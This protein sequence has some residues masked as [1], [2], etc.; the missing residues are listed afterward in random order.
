LARHC[1]VAARARRDAYAASRC[2]WTAAMPP[3]AEMGTSVSPDENMSLWRCR[4]CMAAVLHKGAR[5]DGSRAGAPPQA[6]EH[7]SKLFEPDTQCIVDWLTHGSWT[8]CV[9][10]CGC[11]AAIC[12]ISYAHIMTAELISSV[13]AHPCFCDHSHSCHTDQMCQTRVSSTSSSQCRR[14]AD[15]RMG[16]LFPPPRLSYSAD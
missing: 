16:E 8:L 14:K 9:T 15:Q 10:W 2:G 7:S 4:H 3:M 13:V 12:S 6:R 11:T 5:H 1:L